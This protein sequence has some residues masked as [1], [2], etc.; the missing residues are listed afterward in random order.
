MYV[1][2][3]FVCNSTV[4]KDCVKNKRYAC[5]GE[6]VNIAQEIATGAVVFL[7]A[8]EADTL[9]GPF[10]VIDEKRTNLEP[11]TWTSSVDRSSVLGEIKVEWEELH[12]LK[13]AQ[14]KFSFLKDLN[15]CTLS[16]FQTQDL[17]DAL[18]E[19]PRHQPPQ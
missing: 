18:K 12:E 14:E 3:V 11:G 10:T 6:Q 19:A 17:L 16:H 8:I 1:G 13:N 2:Y 15:T 5:S 4:L 9:I 7:H